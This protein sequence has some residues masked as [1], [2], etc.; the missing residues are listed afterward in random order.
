M[1]QVEMEEGV[2][3][4][5][6]IAFFDG[7]DAIHIGTLDFSTSL[8]YL[9]DP[10]HNKVRGVLR[11]AEKVVLEARTRRRRRRGQNDST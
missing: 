11:E 1:C 8:G 9:W 3:K 7:V 4:A 5:V 2:E 6:D 10:G